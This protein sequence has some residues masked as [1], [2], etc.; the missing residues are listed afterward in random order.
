MKI[1]QWNLSKSL[2]GGGSRSGG[3]GNERGLKITKVHCEH[4][5]KCHNET[6]CTTNRC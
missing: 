2:K 4:I 5:W 6:L 1:E 3:R